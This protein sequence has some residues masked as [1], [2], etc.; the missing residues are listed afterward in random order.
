MAGIGG[1][2]SPRA[3][4]FVGD[5]YKTKVKFDR[6]SSYSLILKKRHFGEATSGGSAL[7][8]IPVL[9]GLY[10]LW[11]G[12]AYGKILIGAAILLTALSFIDDSAADDWLSRVPDSIY[13]A[14]TFA[15]CTLTVLYLFLSFKNHGAEH[16]AI[17]ACNAC[18][19]VTAD[20]IRDASRVAS[21]C[22]T[23]LLSIMAV[24]MLLLAVVPDISIYL[25]I[26]LSLAIS[27][28]ILGIKDGDKKPVLKYVYR[29][30]YFVQRHIVT[31]EPE[32]FRL[33]GAADAVNLLVRAENGQLRPEDC[34]LIQK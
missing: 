29:V 31:R 22:G 16:K 15:V 19:T 9:R 30:G 20:N 13:C 21:R 33:R 2:S 10:K 7:S 28:E 23:N 25:K 4:E 14:G 3:I 12:S 34:I 17:N 18:G 8:R 11:S 6:S 26:L 32:D 1:R 5:R 27:Y 24:V